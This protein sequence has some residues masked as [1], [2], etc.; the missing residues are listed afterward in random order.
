MAARNAAAQAELDEQQSLD[1]FSHHWPKSNAPARAYERIK[2]GGLR[3]TEW[4]V[5]NATVEGVFRGRKG[6]MLA[7]IGARGPGKTQLAVCAMH[8]ACRS[9]QTTRYVKAMDFFSEIKGAYQ[10]GAKDTERSVLSRFCQPRL[11]VIDGVEERGETAWED[12]MLTHVLDKRYDD[13]KDTILIGN[14]KPEEFV[15]SV[16]SSVESRLRETGGIIVCEWPSFRV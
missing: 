4:C 10:G 6:V 9:L 11:L 16:G 1:F 12:Q 7:L 14:L 15:R 13:M 3:G 8:R 2:S 5:A